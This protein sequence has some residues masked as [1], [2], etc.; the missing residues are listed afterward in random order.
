[1]IFNI[2]AKDF[3]LDSMQL[4]ILSTIGCTTKW[5]WIFVSSQKPLLAGSDKLY[6]V[7]FKILK[8][9]GFQ[10]VIEFKIPVLQDISEDPDGL[11]N[12]GPEPFS[13]STKAISI[14]FLCPP[15]E[16]PYIHWWQT[17]FHD[18]YY[19]LACS[20]EFP[21]NKF[22]V[23]VIDI[24]LAEALRHRLLNSLCKPDSLL[25][26]RRKVSTDSRSDLTRSAGQCEEE[27][28]SV[29]TM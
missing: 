23:L 24:C 12:F 19:R 25:K 7:L 11:H 22:L 27:S 8:Q 5:V 4:A 17:W 14:I 3:E 2:G 9:E 21:A 6:E 16:P 1:M 29:V 10:P 28:V 20:W 18:R 15:V 13:D 26:R